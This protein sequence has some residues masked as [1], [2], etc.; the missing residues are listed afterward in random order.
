[1][2]D[3]ND[4]G[5]VDI[6]IWVY[7]LDHRH[8]ENYYLWDPEEEDFIRFP[9][10]LKEYTSDLLD[11]GNLERSVPTVHYFKEYVSESHDQ[12][13]N[14]MQKFRLWRWNEYQLYVC[15]EIEI[16]YN[17]EEEKDI[18]QIRCLGKDGEVTVEKEMILEG[19]SEEQW[20]AV[21]TGYD[22][23]GN[24]TGKWNFS[25]DKS[26][27]DDVW[28]KA[29]KEMHIQISN[30]SIGK[31][32]YLNFENGDADYLETLL[33]SENANDPNN[34]VKL[35]DKEAV[36]ELIQY[37]RDNHFK[38]VSGEYKIPQTSNYEELISIL[39]FEIENDIE[40]NI[41]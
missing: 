10:S 33:E 28:K 41:E 37:M 18:Y 23:N 24:K 36:E 6:R 19:N 32:I 30:V 31:T 4:D 15:A 13:G 38:I 12:D 25:H 1:M 11:N 8:A 2:D 29:E 35:L 27:W 21:V 16:L 5:Y 9:G 20:E 7:E 40:E 17:D 39:K 3:C 14:L 22:Q 26:S 34:K